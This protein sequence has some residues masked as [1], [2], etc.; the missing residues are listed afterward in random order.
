[1]QS[2]GP[3]IREMAIPAELS[4]EYILN[5]ACLTIRSKYLMQLLNLTFVLFTLAQYNW[6]SIMT[7]NYYLF[8][9]R[10]LS[11]EKEI[12]EILNKCVLLHQSHSKFPGW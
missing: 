8:I 5:D 12:Q 10:R 11:K 9:R 1:M 3:A 7:N 2:F 4:K 6:T